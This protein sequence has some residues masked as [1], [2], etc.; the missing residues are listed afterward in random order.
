[1]YGATDPS[2]SFSAVECRGEASRIIRVMIPKELISEICF[3]HFRY[4]KE[5]VGLAVGAETSGVVVV[6]D[7]VIGENLAESA[8]R[9]YL[10]PLAVV[11][12]Y[13]YAE[14]LGNRDIVALIHTH[15]GSAYPSYADLK[16]MELWPLPWVI[17][18]VKDCS[19]KAWFKKGEEVRE[20]LVEEV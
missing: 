6:E 20:V 18:S 1:V 7:I 13:N 3:L 5:V 15:P 14:L 9:F 19:A 12:A 4:G 17:V 8:D 10:D 16:G 2:G 11:E